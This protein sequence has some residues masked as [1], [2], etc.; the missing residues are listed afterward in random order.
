[1]AAEYAAQQHNLLG[2]TL[3]VKKGGCLQYD[4]LVGC[5]VPSRVAISDRQALLQLE[6]ALGG[7]ALCLKEEQFLVIRNTQSST[8]NRKRLT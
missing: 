7:V 6:E 3:V 8:S 1:M 5:A 4:K 2:Y